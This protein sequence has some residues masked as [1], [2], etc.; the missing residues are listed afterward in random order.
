[1]R[2]HSIRFKTERFE[3]RA[4]PPE[5]SNAGNRIHGGD[6]A[7]FLAKGLTTASLEMKFLDEDWGWMVF[8]QTD[9]NIF[10]EI[11]IYNIAED[12]SPGQNGRNEWGLWLRAFKKERW[13]VVFRKSREVEP[14]ERFSTQLRMLLESSGIEPVEWQTP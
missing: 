5:D 9:D 1:M 3:Y 14:P 2:N 8:G 7:E 13:L 12:G 10:L 4:D 6:L 11:A